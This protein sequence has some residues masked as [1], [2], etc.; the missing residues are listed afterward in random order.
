MKCLSP[1]WA[2]ERRVFPHEEEARLV[3]ALAERGLEYYEFEGHA[4]QHDDTLSSVAV[5][6]GS[7]YF[8][9]ELSQT[10]GWLKKLFGLPDQFNCQSYFPVFKDHLLNQEHR[11][12]SFGELCWTHD[13][14]VAELGD[15]NG[16]LFV[17][18]DDGFKSFEGALVCTEDYEP[19]MKRQQLLQVSNPTKIIVARPQPIITEWRVLMVG[20]RAVA[21]SQYKP[22]RA[23]DTPPEVLRF[24]E[25]VHQQ[26]QWPLGAYSMDIADTGSELRIVEVGSLL[27]V[28]FYEADAGAIIDAVQPLVEAAIARA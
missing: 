23:S 12:M 27:C 20:G 7:C 13:R 22:T 28:A 19:W 11:M 9:R 2:V 25:H 18:P 5:A 4:F 26:V 15:T 21:A 6:R 17:R 14:V 10:Q 16:R 8:V 24:A 3:T 1:N